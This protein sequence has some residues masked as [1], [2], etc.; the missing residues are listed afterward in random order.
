MRPDPVLNRPP[1]PVP[2]T[3]PV[4]NGPVGNGSTNGNGAQPEGPGAN[5]PWAERMFN[6]PSFR[7]LWLAQVVSSLGDWIGLVAIT[8]L[9]ARIAGNSP[10]AAVGFVLSARLLP[11]F[12]F[13]QVAGVLVDRFDR[14]RVMVCCDIGRAAV[15][16]L[17]P[18]SRHVWQL[19]LASLLLE[20]MTLLW[21]PA[22]EA[23]VPNLVD[24]SFL[25]NAN[26]L[27]LAAAY[28]TFPV[29]A[30][31][32]TAL[33][34]VSAALGHIHALHVLEVSQERLAFWVDTVTFAT[35]AALISTLTLPKRAP[36]H[37]RQA[38]RL[39][40]A[41]EEAKEG[42]RF[43]RSNAVVRAVILSLATGLIGGGMMVPLGP[44]FA[45][46]VIGAGTR[47]FGTL[48]TGLGL[49]VA[50]GVLGLTVLQRRIRA[51]RVFAGA[52][53]GAGACLFAG[54]SMGSLGPA[55]LFV[56]G[57]G[58]C[59]GAVYVLGFSLIQ[60]HTS[61]SIRGR[62]F[63]TLYTL[64]RMSVLISFILGP[65]LAGAL[66]GLPVSTSGSRITLWLAAGLIVGVGLA[67]GR[68]LRKARQTVDH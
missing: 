51:E 33:A 49:G 9:A 4:P 22:K 64:V 59:V 24:E 10:E 1:L 41:F 16:A 44:V 47:G 54:A 52:V 6:T 18:L 43:I 61:D 3:D 12:F 14:R 7:R 35:S 38:I 21:Q 42:W 13:G 32:F 40:Q 11:G 8:A 60:S 58:M 26:S 50:A 65:F 45:R 25:Q 15:L 67:A 2:T 28:G 17:L 66:D 48:M 57:V 62:T 63:A 39:G 56:F 34:S 29:G 5:R 19:F 30:V 23:S 55:F 68:T 20:V 46:E 27:S 36:R 31:I 37:E 53:V